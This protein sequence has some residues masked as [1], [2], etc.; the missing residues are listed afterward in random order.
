M[1]LCFLSISSNDDKSDPAEMIPLSS[2]HKLDHFTATADSTSDVWPTSN[3][4]RST[5]DRGRRICSNWLDLIV[6]RTEG[7]NGQ[8]QTY[9]M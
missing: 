5:R 4:T 7:L 3:L 8:C 6:K 9:G 1:V 2:L